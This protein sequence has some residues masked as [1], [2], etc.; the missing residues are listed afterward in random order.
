MF[1]VLLEHFLLEPLKKKPIECG[2]SKI[3]IFSEIKNLR[4]IALRDFG[5][6]LY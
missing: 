5:Y 3:Y 1:T 2:L 6:F 4:N